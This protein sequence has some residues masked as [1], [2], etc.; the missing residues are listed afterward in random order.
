MSYGMRKYTPGIILHVVWYTKIYPWY[1]LASIIK[2]LVHREALCV[3]VSHN[4]KKSVKYSLVPCG[5]YAFAAI[6]YNK[7]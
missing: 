7:T 3:M 5:F 6:S 4:N 1:N 2:C